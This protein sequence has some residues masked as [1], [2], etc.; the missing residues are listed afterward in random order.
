MSPEGFLSFLQN[1]N[2]FLLGISCSGMR[3]HPMG[4]L[5]GRRATRVSMGGR[6]APDR[7]QCVIGQVRKYSLEAPGDT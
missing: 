7:G 5:M 1:V 2:L 3:L 4:F 6:K